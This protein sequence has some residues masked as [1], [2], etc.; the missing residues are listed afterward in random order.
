MLSSHA[1]RVP[2]D[3]GRSAGHTSQLIKISKVGVLRMTSE[4]R[5]SLCACENTFSR[6][7]SRSE[8]AGANQKLW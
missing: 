6:K 2:R 8:V 4:S 1:T 3:I 7:V 5:F